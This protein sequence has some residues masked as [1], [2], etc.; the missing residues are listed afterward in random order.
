MPPSG[1]VK[2]P[3]DDDEYFERMTRSLFT[4]GHNW[5]MI[6][7]RWPNFQK[8][9]S[10][11][12]P[13]IVARFSEKDVGALMKEEGIV[14]NERKIRATIHNAGQVLQLQK[15]FGSV[16]SYLDSF[17]KDEESL[18]A[19]LQKRFQHMGASTARMFLWAVGYPLTPNSEEK[20]WI[21][22]NM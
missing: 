18:Q 14:R 17:G 12:S 16:G 3:K 1:K 20:S 9:F 11:F 19:D 7:K 10:G 22:K 6:D 8:A 21:G 2:R 15:K 13:N 5:A 4:A